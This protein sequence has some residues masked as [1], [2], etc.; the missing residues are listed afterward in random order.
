[1]KRL[2]EKNFAVGELAAKGFQ[3]C[4]RGAIIR[5]GLGGMRSSEPEEPEVN[6]T[7][8]NPS[9]SRAREGAG[10]RANARGS[11]WCMEPVQLDR[12]KDEHVRS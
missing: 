8:P 5:A 4:G 2:K 3:W 11:V 10:P 6:G 12:L 9:Q 7:S 1:M